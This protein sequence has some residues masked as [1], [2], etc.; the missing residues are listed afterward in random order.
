MRNKFTKLIFAFALLAM[1]GANAGERL[2]TLSNEARYN[3]PGEWEFEQH[4]TW[5]TTGAN[6]L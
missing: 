4:I 2:F 6:L 1:I 3:K 5:Q